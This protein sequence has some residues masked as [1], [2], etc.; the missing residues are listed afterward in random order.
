MRNYFTGILVLLIVI[1]GSIS[2]VSAQRYKFDVSEYMTKEEVKN[3]YN[4]LANNTHLNS[5]YEKNKKNI[6]NEET[7][8]YAE[9]SS[10]KNLYSN[11]ASKISDNNFKIILKVYVLATADYS[12]ALKYIDRYLKEIEKPE[13]ISNEIKAEVFNVIKVKPV[14]EYLA[15]IEN[16]EVKKNAVEL[17]TL[18]K[19]LKD[20]IVETEGWFVYLKDWMLLEKEFEKVITTKGLEDLKIRELK[21]IRMNIINLY[22]NGIG[23]INY[24]YMEKIY[25]ENNIKQ[26][27]ITPEENKKKKNFVKLIII[28][29]EKKIEKLISTGKLSKRDTEL[30]IELQKKV[31]L[32]SK[33]TEFFLAYEYFDFLEKYADD[34]K[35]DKVYSRETNEFIDAF[36]KLYYNNGYL[37][38]V[39]RAKIKNAKI[40]LEY[41]NN[42]LHQ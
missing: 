35:T 9:Y 1:A 30:L 17:N 3:Y 8:R 42:R 11:E 31:R 12:G 6:E 23:N 21:N 25:A 40:D 4:S 7:K 33:A 19:E 27:L 14:G 22:K 15:N 41:I 10:N 38:M 28:N 18:F 13:D 20:D 39:I 5:D 37:T 2:I 29:G 16:I 34:I 24:L 32:L 36:N 26:Y